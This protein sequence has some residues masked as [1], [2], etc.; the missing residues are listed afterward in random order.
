MAQF[1]KEVLRELNTPKHVTVYKNLPPGWVAV[2]V[3]EDLPV[4]NEVTPVTIT[5]L[6]YRFNVESDGKPIKITYSNGKS[7]LLNEVGKV[8]PQPPAGPKT[9]EDPENPTNKI[10]FRI[11]KMP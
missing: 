9:F 4:R 11:Y 5:N 2:K 3:Q 6:T 1:S 7:Y 8:L 10:A